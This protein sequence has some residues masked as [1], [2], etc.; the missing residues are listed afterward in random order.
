MQQVRQAMAKGQWLDA[1]RGLMISDSDCAAEL[2]RHIDSLEHLLD[3]PAAGLTP[4][5]EWAIIAAIRMFY[6]LMEQGEESA[7]LE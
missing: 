7:E 1:G 2:R 5:E 6:R 4:D 3:R